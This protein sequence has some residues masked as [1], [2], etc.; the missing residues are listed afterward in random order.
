MKISI[1]S[2]ARFGSS[3]LPGKVLMKIRDSTLLGIH[4]KRLKKVNVDY[5]IIVATTNEFEAEEIISI[6]QKEGCLYFRGSLNDVLDRYYHASLIIPSNYIVRVTSD[7][8]LI[9]PILVRNVIQYAIDNDYSYCMTSEKFPDGVDVEVFK[10][11]ELK[12]AFFNA[13][14][15]SEREHVTPYIRSKCKLNGTYGE[16]ECIEGEFGN[17]RMTVDEKSDFIN[18]KFL[19]DNLGLELSWLD[20]AK[21]ITTNYNLFDNQH[22]IRNSGYLKSLRNDII[23]KN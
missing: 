20:Y 19:I 16:F 22:L 2:Q 11:E 5:S 6:A 15:P 8:P 14:L 10:T 4:L 12:E 3:R 13:K 17:V 23:N 18:L 1:I 7:C 9:D 21:F